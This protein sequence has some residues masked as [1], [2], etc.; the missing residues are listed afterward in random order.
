[1]RAPDHV[2]RSLRRRRWRENLSRPALPVR[3]EKS[4]SYDIFCGAGGGAVDAGR[5]SID[6]KNA[7]QVQRPRAVGSVGHHDQIVGRHLPCGH[8]LEQKLLDVRLLPIRNSLSARPT[9]SRRAIEAESS[10]R[11]HGHSYRAEVSV[12][13][14]ANLATGMVV[15]LGLF[16]RALQDARD[17]LDHRYLDEVPDLG[18]ATMENLS[19][20]IWRR[21]SPICA[22]L[23]RVTV[24]RDSS[25][26]RCVAILD[27]RRADND[28][29]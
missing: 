14:E 23:T 12:R 16:E 29:G 18:P 9:F 2:R 4:R 1:M 27:L 6:A 22:G 28:K 7:I 15:D 21:V 13:G 3:I 26:D 10:L 24:Y 19:A 20:W 11:I 8:R 25:G 5:L 17:G